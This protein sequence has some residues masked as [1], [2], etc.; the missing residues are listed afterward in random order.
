[1]LTNFRTVKA[2]ITRLKE[3]EAMSVDGSFEKLV[4]HEVLGLIR[5]KDKLERS[6]GGI[7]DMGRLPDALFVIDI[8]HEDIAV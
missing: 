8:G 7:K 2:S 1:M 5:E 6:L 3:I 4:K